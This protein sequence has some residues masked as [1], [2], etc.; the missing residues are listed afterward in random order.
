MALSLNKVTLIGNVGRDPEIR[1]TG[2]GKEIA[3]LSLAT[4]D[5]WKDKITGERKEKTEWHR[6]I[7]WR[8]LA[9]VCGKYLQK[10][11]MVYVH[12]KITYRD[13]EDK[14]GV[15]RS[16]TEIVAD[17]VEFLDSK[18]KSEGGN[19]KTYQPSGKPTD[20]SDIPF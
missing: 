2:D 12:G 18:P 20:D 10:G 9:D 8:Q 14:D 16:T 17:K 15:K 6:I 3:T 19:Q 11:S 13:W 1:T 5:S 7:A 4:S